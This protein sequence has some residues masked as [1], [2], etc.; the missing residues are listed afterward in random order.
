MTGTSISGNSERGGASRFV[1][2]AQTSSPRRP[3]SRHRTNLAFLPHHRKPSVSPPTKTTRR[4]QQFQAALGVLDRQLERDGRSIPVWMHAAAV[5]LRMGDVAGAE[6]SLSTASFLARSLPGPAAGDDPG[7]PVALLKAQGLLSSIKRDWAAAAGSFARC[8]S[9]RSDDAEAAAS[10]AICR[11]HEGRPA[12]AIAGLEAAVQ[13]ADAGAIQV[14][15]RSLAHA[16][17]RAC[18]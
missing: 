2:E 13:G 16:R 5:Q 15:A 8:V 9:R 1:W 17:A 3:S 12:E 14:I 4:Q 11:L 7:A 6:A 10:L 18:A